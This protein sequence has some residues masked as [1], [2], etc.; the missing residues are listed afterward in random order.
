MFFLVCVL[1][2]SINPLG[3]SAAQYFV[4]TTG[5]DSNSGTIGSP[6]RTI[7]KGAS[8]MS[9]GDTMFIRAGTYQ[10]RAGNLAIPSGGGSWE[11]ATTIAAY[12]KEKVIIT[13]YDTTT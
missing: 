6:F 8:G 1:V 9:S 10:R 7:E 12:N 11:T 5:N 3:A 2:V 13:P 4:A